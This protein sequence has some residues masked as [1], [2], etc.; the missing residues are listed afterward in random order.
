MERHDYAFPFRIDPVSGQAAH[1]AYPD[2]VGQMVRQVLLT[3]PGERIDLPEFGCGLRQLVFA[4]ES[5]AL[6][7]TTRLLVQ[8]ALERWL[9]GQVVVQNVTVETAEEAGD[10][11]LRV[12]IDYTLVET[13]TGQSTTVQVI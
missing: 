3:S 11:Q 13:R 9:A 5:D 6:A 8:Q 10:G 4:P 1:A 7:S 2:H 12:R